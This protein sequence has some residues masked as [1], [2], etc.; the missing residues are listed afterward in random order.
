MLNL[1][2][3]S[4]EALPQWCRAWREFVMRTE[5][6]SVKEQALHKTANNFRGNT[7]LKEGKYIHRFPLSQPRP[8]LPRT[9]GGVRRTRLVTENND[10]PVGKKRA[11]EECKERESF[12]MSSELGPNK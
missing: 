11:G 3:N 4:V 1:A 9:D 8:V 2:K 6:P 5:K 7:V 12:I 10:I